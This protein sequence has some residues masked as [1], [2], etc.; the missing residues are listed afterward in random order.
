MRR[1]KTVTIET[2][3]VN[4]RDRGKTFLVTE[5]PAAQGEEWAFRALCAMAKSGVQLPDDY[6]NMSMAAIAGLGFTALSGMQFGD[7]KPLL[8][9]MM[10]CVKFVGDPAKPDAT[11]RALIGQDDI[12]EISTRLLLRKEVFSLHTDFFTAAKP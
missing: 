3:D 5:M 6:S 2:P 8:D 12:E 4:N 9:E 1:T 7:A 11:T 10:D